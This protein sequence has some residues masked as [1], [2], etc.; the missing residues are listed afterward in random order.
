MFFSKKKICQ[1]ILLSGGLMIGNISNSH[2]IQVNLPVT[3]A[4]NLSLS[5]MQ[6]PNPTYLLAM[7]NNLQTSEFAWRNKQLVVYLLKQAAK[8]GS[9]EAQFQL[10]SF[11]LNG[12]LLDKDEDK[13][14]LWLGKAASQDHWPA[15][16]LYDQIMSADFGIGC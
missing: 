10:G 2:A 6:N 16:F 4:T 13:A 7:A 14:L 5:V 15:Q 8:Q 3:M 1:G 11:Y 9:A 12:E